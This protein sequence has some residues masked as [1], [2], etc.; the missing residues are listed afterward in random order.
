VLHEAAYSA[1][2]KT[3]QT[4]QQYCSVFCNSVSKS[5]KGTAHDFLHDLLDTNQRQSTGEKTED[6]SAPNGFQ[7]T[8]SKTNRSGHC[9]T[10]HF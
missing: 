2:S 1:E 9:V 5:K 3:Q 7:E 10:C 6:E 4:W 8:S